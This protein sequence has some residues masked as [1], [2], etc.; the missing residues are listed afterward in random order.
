M[1]RLTKNSRLTCHME[2]E[3]V[4]GQ[5]VCR[6]TILNNP[7]DLMNHMID[8]HGWRL[9]PELAQRD[10]NNKK[11]HPKTGTV[12]TESDYLL[13]IEFNPEEWFFDNQL[14]WS[15]FRNSHFRKK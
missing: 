4:E 3:W 5:E 6:D 1:T 15:E 8:R 10:I 2:L 12:M 13:F 14:I 11:P 9:I 7:V